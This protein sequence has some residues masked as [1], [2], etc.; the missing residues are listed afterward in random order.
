MS[1][2]SPP[3][4]IDRLIG[5]CWGILGGAIAL[6]C[7]VKLLHAILPALIVVVGALAIVGLVVGV[8]IV[9]IRTLRNRW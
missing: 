1:S 4:W 3:R 8:G 9:V 5:W 6:Y 2:D 7:A